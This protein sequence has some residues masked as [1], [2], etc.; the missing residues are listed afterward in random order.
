[1]SVT[2]AKWNNE[3]CRVENGIFFSDDSVILLSGTPRDGYA[4]SDR[5]ELSSL[6]EADPEG[7]TDIEVHAA[8]RVEVGGVI[9][10]AGEGA[11]EG[12]GFVAALRASDGA[13]LWVLHLHA[14]EVFREVRHE[15]DVIQA[16]SSEYPDEYQWRI[17]ISAPGMLSVV[18]H[19]AI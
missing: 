4:A 19:R 7:W 13:L 11:W 10:T 16:V 1:M 8:C 2:Q 9:V 17:P 3:Q 5:I 6:L 12:E 14:S 18:A 15:G